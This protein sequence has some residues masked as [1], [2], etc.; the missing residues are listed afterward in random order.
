MIRRWWNRWLIR[1][2]LVHSEWYRATYDATTGWHESFR[3]RKGRDHMDT[4]AWVQTR[5]WHDA[6]PTDIMDR[7]AFHIWPEPGGWRFGP[8]PERTVLSA[9]FSGDAEDVDMR[10][11]VTA[12]DWSIGT[13]AVLG[14]ATWRHALTDAEV[15]EANAAMTAD[16]I[17]VA[18]EAARARGDSTQGA[19]PAPE[20]K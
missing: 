5:R 13:P 6:A 18:I 4:D 17:T 15:R 11:A 20:I 3:L 2:R 19:E 7:A 8:T 10:V 16:P 14:A 9:S 1:L 12:D